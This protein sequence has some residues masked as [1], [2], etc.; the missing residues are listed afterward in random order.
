VA[1]QAYICTIGTQERS[2]AVNTCTFRPGK[3]ATH[4]LLT[5]VLLSEVQ[6]EAIR[7]HGLVNPIQ[8]DIPAEYLNNDKDLA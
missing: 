8:D 2:P 3:P 7:I 6:I 4:F 5:A 1:H